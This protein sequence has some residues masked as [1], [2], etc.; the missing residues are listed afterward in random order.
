MTSAIVRCKFCRKPISRPAGEVNR[1][2]RNGSPIYCDRRCFGLSRRVQRS[3][4]ERV[5]AKAAY[6]RE[7][8]A[9]HGA[10]LRRKK[11]AYYHRTFDPVKAK[12]WRSTPERRAY[13][14]AYC[15]RPEYRAK[16]HAYDIRRSSMH[17]VGGAADWA[18]CHRL[19]LELTR[20]INRQCPDKYLRLKARGYYDHNAQ[21][22]RR[23]AH[24]NRH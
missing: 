14:R 19:L 6:D 12:A 17:A 21:Q 5:A 22:R 15:Q 2:L 1:A 24:V 11:R 10:K 8:R 7:Y 23:N 9:R 20:E 18:E 3:K 4:A 16:K 13:H